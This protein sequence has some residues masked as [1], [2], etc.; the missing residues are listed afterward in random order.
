M[1]PTIETDEPKLVIINRVCEE[2]TCAE[3]LGDE[4]TS[5]VE[6]TT[7]VRSR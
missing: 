6:S 2:N 5:E 4:K 3:N 7:V 1:I